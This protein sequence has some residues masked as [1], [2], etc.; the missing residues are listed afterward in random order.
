MSECRFFTLSGDFENNDFGGVIEWRRI[1]HL[2]CRIAIL[3]RNVDLSITDKIFPVAQRIGGGEKISAGQV[4]R[5][6]D[7]DDFTAVPHQRAH[8]IDQADRIIQKIDRSFGTL[9]EKRRIKDDGIKRSAR[10]FECGHHRE[11][12]A[13][14]DLHFTGIKSIEFHRFSGEREKFAGEVALGNLRRISRQRGDA[15]TSGVG[16]GVKD[17]FI[18]R[19]FNQILP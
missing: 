15:Q 5:V 2:H 10:F 14:D 13:L 8:L 1:C 17:S 6:I 18:C 19:I 11:K 7:H 9:T 3:F 12:V 4:E 16:E